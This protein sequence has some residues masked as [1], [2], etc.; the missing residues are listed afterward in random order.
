V[1]VVIVSASAVLI[2]PAYGFGQPVHCGLGKFRLSI[3]DW[4][5]SACP[6]VIDFFIVLDV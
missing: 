2:L 4:G 3:G 6:L 1:A 5:N